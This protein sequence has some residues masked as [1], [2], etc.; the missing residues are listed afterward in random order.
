MKK[1]CFLDSCLGFF[2]SFLHLKMRYQKHYP[3]MIT[4]QKHDNIESDMF[5]FL[6]KIHDSKEF[7]LSK[8]AETVF[9]DIHNDMYNK[10]R[11]ETKQIKDYIDP[12]LRRWSPYILKI[13]MLLHLAKDQNSNTLDKNDIEGGGHVVECAYK[14]TKWL[15][16]NYIL[17]SE[18]A[19]QSKII[20]R[21]IVNEGGKCFR[22]KL[23]QN[24][25]NFNANELDK[26]IRYLTETDQIIIIGN[27]LKT[28]EAY[29]I[30]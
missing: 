14:S 16:N 22:P 12:F 24:N 3:M 5:N 9:T 1:M 15:L 11:S 21:Y 23:M 26:I 2:C 28:K 7:S 30:V 4:D 25:A 27:K 29:Q 10:V 8:E 20:L 17:E 18:V 6:L 19:K 13:A